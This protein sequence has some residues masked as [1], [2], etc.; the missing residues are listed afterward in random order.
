MLGA[1]QKISDDD[2]KI[3]FRKFIFFRTL[4]RGGV[5]GFEEGETIKSTDGT[6]ENDKK[7]NEEFLFR[8]GKSA[9]LYPCYR[10]PYAI[11]ISSGSDTNNFIVL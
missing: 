8:L 11:L 3:C 10:A 4:R 5:I 2:Q 9:I 6:A 1:F 7:L